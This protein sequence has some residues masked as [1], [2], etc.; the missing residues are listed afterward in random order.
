MQAAIRVSGVAL[1]VDCA[2]DWFGA[3][4]AKS[5]SA[6]YTT[7]AIAKKSPSRNFKFFM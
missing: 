7:K 2:E 1:R 3:L 4:S 6:I 5:G